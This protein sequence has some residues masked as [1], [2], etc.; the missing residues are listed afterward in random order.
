MGANA[1]L[2]WV[3]NCVRSE[4]METGVEIKMMKGVSRDLHANNMTMNKRT[5]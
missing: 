1:R 4:E 5:K 3:K 2:D